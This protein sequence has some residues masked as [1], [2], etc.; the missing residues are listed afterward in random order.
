MNIS[1]RTLTIIQVAMAVFLALL[2][3]ATAAAVLTPNAITHLDLQFSR[4]VIDRTTPA[5]DQIFNDISD[6]GEYLVIRAGTV[7]VDLYLLYRG[8]WRR[9]LL[10]TGL[11]AVSVL[12]NPVVKD[13]ILRPRPPFPQ[14]YLYGK[15]PSFPS[16]HTMLS[17]SFYA[18]IA[19]FGW[20]FGRR[21]WVRW[22][23]AA[24]CGLLVLLIGISRVYLGV[25]FFTDVLGGWAIGGMLF[26]LALLIGYA[27]FY[28]EKKVE[29]QGPGQ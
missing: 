5:G 24:L 16:G 2:F 15:D 25:H 8:E 21:A 19:Y 17:A 26:L 9:A 12:L 29:G 13:I 3:L 11:I 1:R 7:V 20:I 6:M 22:G 4:W 18:M 28:R 14:D 23:I 10:F 27:L